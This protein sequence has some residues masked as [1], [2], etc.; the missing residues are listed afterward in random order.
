MHLFVSVI[1]F[2]ID[3]L[4]IIEQ[5]TAESN[6]LFFLSFQLAEISNLNFVIYIHVD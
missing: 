4:I 6:A 2:E 1:I 5:S 3:G